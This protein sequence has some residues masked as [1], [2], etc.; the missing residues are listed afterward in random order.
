MIEIGMDMFDETYIEIF[1]FT[2]IID[3]EVNIFIQTIYI[4]LDVCSNV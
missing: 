3:F 2:E 4:V 1:I